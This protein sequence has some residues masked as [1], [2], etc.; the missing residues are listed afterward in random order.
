MTDHAICK[1][2]FSFLSMLYLYHYKQFWHWKLK[3][4]GC[5]DAEWIHTAQERVQWLAVMAMIR[6]L[7]SLKGEEFLD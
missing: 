5:G 7:D 1:C 4:T 3:E 6:N 2:C